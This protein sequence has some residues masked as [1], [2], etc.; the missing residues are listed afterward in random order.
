M[1]APDIS[2]LNV[3]Q[4][5]V[6]CADELIQVFGISD[7]IVRSPIVGKLE[8]G[9]LGGGIATETVPVDNE[10]HIAA[11]LAEETQTLHVGLHDITGAGGGWDLI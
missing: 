3:I 2:L 7:S 11:V 9:L 1:G 5:F 4:S 8:F 10:G 6:A